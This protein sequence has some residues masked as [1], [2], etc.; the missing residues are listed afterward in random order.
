M[1]ILDTDALGHIQKKDP[2][3]VLIEAA[4]DSSP[5]RDIW[6]TSV[7]A[8]E[9]MSG[10]LTLIDRR[11]RGAQRPDSCISSLSGSRRIPRALEGTNPAL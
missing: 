3:G 8:Y 9:M 5:D 4:I 7:T 10:G 11:K 2:V 1:I 6:I